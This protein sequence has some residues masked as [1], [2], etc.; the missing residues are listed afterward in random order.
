MSKDTEGEAGQEQKVPA[1][2]VCPNF[3]HPAAH[4]YSLLA[5]A[6]AF[7][8][9]SSHLWYFS[10]TWFIFF[11]FFFSPTHPLVLFCFGFLFIYLSSHLEL[12]QEKQTVHIHNMT[13]AGGWI[14]H[15]SVFCNFCCILQDSRKFG[16]TDPGVAS[17]LPPPLLYNRPRLGWQH[18]CSQVLFSVV[19]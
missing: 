6:L 8:A 15:P 11:F 4:L 14:L 9:L 1:Q 13:K 18:V 2:R 7:T 16:E 19:V 12:F 3:P 10:T 5:G 17:L